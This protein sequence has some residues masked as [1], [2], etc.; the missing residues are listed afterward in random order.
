VGGCVEAN[1]RSGAVRDWAV[2]VNEKA[3]V[4]IRVYEEMIVA[5]L[6]QFLLPIGTTFPAGTTPRPKTRRGGIRSVAPR[7]YEK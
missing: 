3:N 2:A 1:N 7:S 5:D 6:K 4:E